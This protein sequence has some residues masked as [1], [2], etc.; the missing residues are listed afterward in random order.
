MLKVEDDAD[1]F[2][3]GRVPAIYHGLKEGQGEIVGVA[4]GM[5][6]FGFDGQ[7]PARTQF[8]V[9]GVNLLNGG[10]T[11]G[12][13]V[14]AGNKKTRNFAR[15]RGCGRGVNPALVGDKGGDAR[16]AEAGETVAKLSTGG[17]SEEKKRHG[18]QL[19]MTTGL[20]QVGQSLKQRLAA[21]PWA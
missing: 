10:T 15:G 19:G 13:V 12:F 2:S 6:L 18:F 20:P 14:G 21:A 11:A 1:A 17:K 3:G 5:P 4:G 7:T 9:F 8:P 16:G